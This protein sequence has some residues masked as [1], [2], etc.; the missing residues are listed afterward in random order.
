MVI[1]HN[2]LA[3][4][5]Y[6]QSNSITSYRKKSTEKL[7]SGYRINRAADDAAGLTISEK[8]RSQIRGLSQGVNNCQDGVSL[9]Q[10]ADGAM[11]EVDNILHRMTELCIKASNGTNTS[12]DRT[13]INNEIQHL[14]KEIDRLGNETSFNEIKILQG[15]FPTGE[16]KTE[17]IT[18]TTIDYVPQT[19]TKTIIEYETQT[20]EQ[21]KEKTTYLQVTGY[22][23]TSNPYVPVYFPG[24]N[25]GQQ[26]SYVYSDSY[27][28]KKLNDTFYLGSDYYDL[29][30]SKFKNH[31]DWAKIDGA[32]FSYECGEGCHQLFSFYFDNTTSGITDM[33]PTIP[34]GSSYNGPSHSK[35]F[36]VGTKDYNSGSDF[37]ADLL[38]FA[39]T[40]GAEYTGHNGIKHTY[41]GHALVL[42]TLTGSDLL[43]TS[44]SDGDSYGGFTMGVPYVDK[45]T[46][47]ITEYI[48]VQVPVEKQIEVEVL[49]P[50]E[51]TVEKEIQTPI[52]EKRDL[53]IQYGCNAKHNLELKLPHIDC[54]ALGM[55]DISASTVHKALSSLDMINSA[56]AKVDE[57][58]SMMGAQQNGLEAL[59]RDEDTTVEN[60]TAAD[61][62][63]CDTD[64]S[65]EMV[66]FSKQNILIQAANAML[67]NANQVPQNILSLF[68]S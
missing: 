5:A 6:I 26:Y 35:T 65:K 59:I 28:S 15:T 58:R 44:G 30:F 53:P 41:I 43:V 31:D 45:R 39:K 2:L 10:V 56:R 27:L 62:R 33:T 55:N 18:Q 9:C 16:Y 63:I 54:D 64:M 24:I 13:A 7:S 52:Y 23:S 29:D 32:A 49:V 4:N 36:T 67:A 46:E 17:T 66:E 19:E 1:S 22:T 48:D 40:T 8:L 57:Y 25:C 60:T 38:H 34:V 37:V 3:T 20:Q 50:V 61:S 12:A 21:T 47:L 51:H 11:S 14:K 68:N 42:N